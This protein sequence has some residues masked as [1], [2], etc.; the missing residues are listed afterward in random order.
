LAW[1]AHNNSR[2]M[3]NPQT[4]NHVSVTNELCLHKL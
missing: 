3:P 2:T 4:L 1:T